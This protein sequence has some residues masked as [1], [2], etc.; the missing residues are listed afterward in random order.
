MT[1]RR[2]LGT[3]VESAAD[4]P[5]CQVRRHAAE[6]LNSASSERAN[7][8]PEQRTDLRGDDGIHLARM[9]GARDLLWG[10]PVSFPFE[11]VVPLEGLEPT[12]PSLRMMCSTI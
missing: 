11:A 3:S 12:T 8:L 1:D 5:T 2:K 9:A 10:G 4:A 7:P 6:L